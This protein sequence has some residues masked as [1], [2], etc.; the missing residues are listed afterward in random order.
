MNILMMTN[1][2][3]PIVGGIEN[4]I[5]TFSNAYR[6]MGHKVLIV[7][8]VFKNMPE[9]EGVHRIP[10]LQ[11]F[12]GTDFSVELPVP[13]ILSGILEKFKP[14]I[15]HSHHPFLVGDTAL[16]V[17]AAKNIPVVFTY[18]TMYE[19]NTHYVP[20]DSEKLKKFVIQLAAGYCDLCA[21]VISPSESVR[22]ILL[23][24][25]VRRKITT[26]PTGVDF[27]RYSRGSGMLFRDS[28]GIPRDCFLIGHLGRAAPEKNI[29]FLTDSV[30]KFM[31]VREDAHFV[32]VGDGELL[33]NVKQ[34]FISRGLRKR[35]HFPGVLK[36]DEKINAYHGMDVFCFASKSE[37]QGLVLLESMSAGVPVI[38]L[39]APGTR[40][41]VKDGINGRLL[42]DEDERA[43]VEALD[44]FRGMDSARKGDLSAAAKDTAAGFDQKKS[45]LKMVEL[46]RDVLNERSAAK[47]A[48]NSL[49]S[50]SKGYIRVELGL[51]TNI[52]KS[53][54]TVIKDEFSRD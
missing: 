32:M 1:T 19:K 24:R 26:I 14:D 42:A 23:Q 15:V 12:N 11:N 49:W 34:R 22:E 47:D 30:A 9:E 46:Y 25:G 28:A 4:S 29:L 43:F 40:D 10:A 5:E 7:A 39:D 33:E 51:V 13:G 2:Y 35:A 52:I 53:A 8:P 20:G 50:T 6:A 17:A 45:V 38:G 41:V 27:Q 31:E 54:G 37:T 3:K 21:R 16:R 44:I 36:G 48:D 18:H